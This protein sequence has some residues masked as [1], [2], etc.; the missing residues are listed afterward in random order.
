MGSKH[1]V[2]DLTDSYVGVRDAGLDNFDSVIV[3]IRDILIAR[4]VRLKL[5]VE[6][7]SPVNR[8]RDGERVQ[9]ERESAGA[10]TPEFDLPVLGGR[11]T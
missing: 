9:R 10:V 2:K 1:P 7:E 5:K 6:I 4:P 8:A 11:I 3:Q